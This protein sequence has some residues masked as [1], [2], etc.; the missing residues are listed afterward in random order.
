[1]FTRRHVDRRYPAIAS[2]LIGVAGLAALGPA[3]QTP[4][5][6]FTFT[7]VADDVYF[8]VGTG[9]LTV[10]C[11]AAIIINANDVLVVDSHVSPA[12]AQAL[13]DELKAITTK[14][15]RYVVNTHFHFDHSSGNQIYGPDVEII[16]H[17]FTREMLTQ[18]ASLRGRGF[19]R[20]IGSL[21]ATIS[22]LKAQRDTAKDTAAVTR[23]IAPQELLKRQT[24]TIRATPPTVA[25]DH[26]MTLFPW[27]ARDPPLF[28]GARAYRRRHRRSSPA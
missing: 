4:A 17:Q 1:M 12:A 8:A 2:I 22:R 21:P 23:L 28:F 13:L 3:P 15:V 26:A 20:Y 25:F 9:A 11:N 14:P 7:K 18:G 27:R 6:A 19:D 5:P 24:D 16:G 10:F